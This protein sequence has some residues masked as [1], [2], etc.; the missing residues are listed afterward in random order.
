MYPRLNID[1]EKLKHNTKTLLEMCRSKG[2]SMS[3][4]TKVFTADP[5]L[6]AV[7][8][9]LSVDFLADSRLENIANYPNKSTK[10]MLL[11]L[12]SIHNAVETVKTCDI[13]FNSEI[14]T[15]HA[16]GE[17]AKKV[18]LNHG[19]ML[20]IDLGDLREGIYYT[21][22]DLI[23]KTAA[24]ILSHP[25]LSL[26]G[27]GVNLTCYGSVLPTNHNLTTL[28]QI[29]KKIE[30]KFDT[31]IDIISGGNSSSLYLLER[32]EMP[33]EVNNLRLG[34][35]LI[36]GMET[37]FG[38]YLPSLKQ[39]VVTLE[40]EM[41]EI[42]EKPS[43]PF[44]ELGMNAFGEKP[45]YTDK[46]VGKRAILAVGRQ[47]IDQEGMTCLTPNVEII[48]ASSDHLIV[49]ITNAGEFVVGDT[50]TFS[51]SYGAILKGF[52]SNYVERN[53]KEAL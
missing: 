32:D 23:F 52:T 19:I 50:L 26:A 17:A 27:V 1:L 11:R 24:D 53:Y 48:G 25:N 39:D 13:S 45:T 5:K 40:A 12:P 47:D 36:R 28:C 30:T 22:Q 15:I 8:Q 31:K 6:V 42:M 41:V 18:G 21:N 43:M 9:D 7:L 37:A 44:G 46:G 14:K 3:V 10:T 35:A 33:K 29:A 34:E 20:M 16:L 38:E 51:L 2:I 49:D 4:V